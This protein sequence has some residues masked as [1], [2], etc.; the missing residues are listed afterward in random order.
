MGTSIGIKAAALGALA[1]A[2]GA[3]WSAPEAQAAVCELTALQKAAGYVTMANT[4]KFVAAAFFAVFSGIFLFHLAPMFAAVPKA[5]WKALGYAGVAAL[6]SAAMWADAASAPYVQF[7]GAALGAGALT[8]LLSDLADAFGVSKR[9]ATAWHASVAV[10]GG[11]LALLESNPMVAG[12]SV[13]GLMGLL[14]FSAFSV[15]GMVGMGFD[16]KAR[17]WRATIGALA[18]LAPT[19]LWRASFGTL[20][21]LEIFWP[22]IGWL[23][24]L[25]AGVG[26]LIAASRY[27]SSSVPYVAR[28]V[29]M[30]AFGLFCIWAGSVHGMVE[31]QRVGGT[32]MVVWLF[33][34][35]WD[36][37]AGGV[38]GYSFLGAA[39]CAGLFVLMREVA[40]HPERWSSFLLF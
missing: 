21:A 35:P 6:C 12:V 33:E 2:A 8:I 18:L 3:A 19:V 40:A 24:A 10:G 7:A 39:S 22:A 5:V 34:K 16:G 1:M 37:P 31:A 4:V 29:L 9:G 25:V 13:A 36:I 32:L 14:G 23:G 28:N 20:G 38:L 27:F 30:L 15:P 17:L 11:M 26:L